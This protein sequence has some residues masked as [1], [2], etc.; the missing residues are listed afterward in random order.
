VI[1]K[2][3]KVTLD[4][5]ADYQKF[6][7]GLRTDQAQLLMV[8]KADETDKTEVRPSIFKHPTSQAADPIELLK[9]ARLA[10]H[11]YNK[12]ISLTQEAN[13]IWKKSG[14][15]PPEYV[16][17]LVM[18]STAKLADD[19][20]TSESNATKDA[21]YSEWKS[22]TAGLLAEAVN[23]GSRTDSGIK[24]VVLALA[25]EL[26]ALQSSDNETASKLR[27][28]AG[29]IR[30]ELVGEIMPE[31]E[32]FRIASPGH[33][34]LRADPQV[35]H[36]TLEEKVEPAYSEAAREVRIAG[37]VHLAV[38]VEKDGTPSSVHLLEGLGFGLDEEAAKAVKQWRFSPGTLDGKPV[39]VR[40]TIEVAF[41]L[42]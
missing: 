12:T 1:I 14:A 38:V 7:K 19:Y 9:G 40:A 33:E 26:Q 3:S 25:L 5:W 37:T 4:Q 6:A 20:S 13:S 30:G 16:E 29:K 27:E 42:L 34:P 2:K 18:L 8:G 15:R 23:I 24:P 17:S 39:R 28:Q 32:A 11:D 21:I 36:P 31:P 41:K 22:E 10:V 35:Q